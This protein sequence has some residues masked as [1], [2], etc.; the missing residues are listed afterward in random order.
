MVNDILELRKEA[1][2]VAM[3]IVAKTE[4]WKASAIKHEFDDM[5]KLYIDI[6]NQHNYLISITLKLRE[7]DIDSKIDYEN[8]LRDLKTSLD[9]LNELKE[10]LA[11]IA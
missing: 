2:E 3:D 7:I 9:N 4:L 1:Y 11:K 6:E 8:T 10:I 5:K